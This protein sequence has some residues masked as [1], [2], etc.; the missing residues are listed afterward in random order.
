MTNLTETS[1][2]LCLVVGNIYKSPIMSEVSSTLSLKS[3]CKVLSCAEYLLMLS[4]IC[5]FA[6]QPETGLPSLILSSVM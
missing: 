6:L 1:N 3:L 5:L 2:F 4:C